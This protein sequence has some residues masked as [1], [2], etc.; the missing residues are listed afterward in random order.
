MQARTTILPKS[1][2]VFHHPIQDIVMRLE[3][4]TSNLDLVKDLVITLKHIQDLAIYE[5]EFALLVHYLVPQDMIYFFDHAV[6]LGI[7]VTD[8]VALHASDLLLHS[9][10]KV[11]GFVAEFLASSA[12]A[13]AHHCLKEALTKKPIHRD[14]IEEAID[15]FFLG[16]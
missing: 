14:V 10:R 13:F 6:R 7:P 5:R 1:T 4:A 8:P 15:L 3:P 9:N 16:D 11:V 2:P 12:N